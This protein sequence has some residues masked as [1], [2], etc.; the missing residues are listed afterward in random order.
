[1]ENMDRG[2]YELK[3]ESFTINRIKGPWD[4]S[5][6]LELDYNIPDVKPDVKKIICQR[7]DAVIEEN[8]RQDRYL[9]VNGYLAFSIL[10]LA[11]EGNEPVQCAQGQIPFEEKLMP[12]EAM[13]D[14]NINIKAVVEDFSVSVVNSRKLSL[15]CIIT[16][17]CEGTGSE[18]VEAAVSMKGKEE[19][20][21]ISLSGSENITQMAVCTRDIYRVKEQIEI[22]SDSPEIS[23]ILYSNISLCSHDF[24][25]M[26]GQIG[27]SGQLKLFAMYSGINGE[28][29]YLDRDISFNTVLEAPGV[30][31]N[32]IE[33][34]EVTTSGIQVVHRADKDGE[35]R[36]IE[37]DVT[38]N[39]FIRVYEERELRLLKD[40]YSG[41]C[42]LKPTSENI[43][44][45]NLA[46]KNNLLVRIQERKLLDAKDLDVLLVCSGSGEAKLD[47]TRIEDGGLTVFGAVELSIM[48]LSRSDDSPISSIRAAFPFSQKIEVPDIREDSIVRL[49]PNINSIMVSVADAR[50][51]D[52]K[53]SVEICIMVFNECNTKIITGYQ[54]EETGQMPARILGYIPREGETLWETAKQFGATMEDIKELNPK[55][56]DGYGPE[57][58]I[59]GKRLL[60][61]Q[62]D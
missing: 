46:M 36:V 41:K 10:Y 51:L 43:R 27:F 19:N 47:G 57:D 17:I 8:R 7:G 42:L 18:R 35:E 1:M 55:V 48:Y 32:M 5:T 25:L 52:V 39:L 54:A 4:F 30:S 23:Q 14:C 45:E 11:A 44:H 40:F 38:L 20:D 13:Q 53:V 29:E 24:R 60:I 28:V 34:I 33:D 3:K 56:L 26:A 31:E 6:T 62:M 61:S 9:T 15:R 21:V 58:D 59:G 50:T 22:P 16:Y 2:G 37:A 12:D 49:R